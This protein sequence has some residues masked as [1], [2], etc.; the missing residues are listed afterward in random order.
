[1]GE[2]ELEMGEVKEERKVDGSKYENARG[3]AGGRVVCESDT[4]DGQAEL[5][6]VAELTTPS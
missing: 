4:V 1:M 6:L 5:G 2:N 3:F